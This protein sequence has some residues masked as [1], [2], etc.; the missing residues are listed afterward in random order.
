MRPWPRT[1]R[2]RLVCARN[3]LAVSKIENEKAT[4]TLSS[5]NLLAMA[6]EVSVP[7][8][9]RA[10]EPSCENEMCFGRSFA[11][12]FEQDRADVLA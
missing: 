2:P 9:L 3:S 7:G 11:E 10:C 1:G 4:P 12:L 6:F 5:L 8:L